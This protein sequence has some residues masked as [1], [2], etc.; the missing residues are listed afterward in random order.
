MNIYEYMSKETRFFKVSCRKEFSQGA[1]YQK[2]FELEVEVTGSYHKMAEQAIRLIREQG[3]ETH[4]IIS[5][6]TKRDTL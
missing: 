5:H 1:F 6:S 2:V 4:H 3:Y